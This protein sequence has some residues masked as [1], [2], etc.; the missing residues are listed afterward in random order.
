MTGPSSSRLIFAAEV[1]RPAGVTRAAF[2]ALG[3]IEA[4][5]CERQML[6]AHARDG[7]TSGTPRP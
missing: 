1:A 4:L 2:R 5:F 7:L 3:E 6:V